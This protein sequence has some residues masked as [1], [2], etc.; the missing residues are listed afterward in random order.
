MASDW[1]TAVVET[2]YLVLPVVV[3]LWEQTRLPRV[4]WGRIGAG[5]LLTLGGRILSRLVLALGPLVGQEWLRLP[6]AGLSL[7]AN[8]ATVTGLAVMG[9]YILKEAY[10]TLKSGG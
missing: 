10:S 7:L 1:V 5:A 6:M 9:F 2:P 8:A 3:W 4:K